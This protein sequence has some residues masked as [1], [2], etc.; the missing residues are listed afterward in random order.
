MNQFVELA[1]GTFLG[2]SG[3]CT[4]VIYFA[5][6][7]FDSHF[8]KVEKKLDIQQKVALEYIGKESGVYPDL[9]ELVYLGKTGSD[10][11]RTAKTTVDLINN[12]LITSCREITDKLRRFRIYLPRDIFDELHQYK[13]LLQ[14]LLVFSDYFTR[15]DMER[16][17]K[18]IPDNVSQKVVYLCD[19]IAEKCN[20][21]IS[22]A[23]KRIHE[24]QGSM[25][26]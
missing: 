16:E 19:Q 23:Q 25:T 26:L 18:E 15:P 24:L 22:K 3:A 8:K 9:C 17:T 4:I 14:D 10:Q 7:Y 5:K 1:I 20:S 2:S 11:C 21:I 12:D 13:H 6:Q